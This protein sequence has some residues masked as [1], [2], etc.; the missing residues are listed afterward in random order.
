MIL[1]VAIPLAVI[2]FGY[3]NATLPLTLHTPT[4]DYDYLSGVFINLNR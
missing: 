1:I 4:D 3:E 2:I